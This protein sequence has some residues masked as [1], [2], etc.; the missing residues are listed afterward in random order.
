MKDE[1]AAILACLQK[2]GS[3]L[4][5][6]DTIWGLG[7][8]AH[9]VAA[10]EQLYQLKQRPA[11]KSLILLVS[12]IEMLKQYVFPVPPKAA[13]L[14]SFHE[15]PL[16]I[17]YDKPKNL[18]KELLAADGSIAIRV[19]QSAFCQDFIRAFG[20][21][22]VSTSANYSGQTSPAHFGE[23]DPSLIEQVDYVCEYGQDDRQEVAPSTIVR[24]G[25]KEELEFIR[26]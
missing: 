1:K 24:I 21:A 3:L 15:R 19:C 12:D 5:P 23:I 14:I 9:N 13:K 17:I 11:E 18:P 16:S 8:D 7:C 25:P 6:T 2:G 10:V 4:Y 26:P 22:V 20:R